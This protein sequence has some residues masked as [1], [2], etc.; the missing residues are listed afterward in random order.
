MTQINNWERERTAALAEMFTNLAEDGTYPVFQFYEKIDKAFQEQITLAKAEERK[1]IVEV[2]EEIDL[3]CGKTDCARGQCLNLRV[4]REVKQ[5][6][7]NK[8]KKYDTKR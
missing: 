4:R 6:L 7:I 2:I 5:E 8:L 1:R 3:S